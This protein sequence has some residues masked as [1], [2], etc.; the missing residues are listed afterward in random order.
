LKDLYAFKKLAWD[1]LDHNALGRVCLDF[2]DSD[3]KENVHAMC[4]IE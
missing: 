1:L 4:A 3:V 2:M